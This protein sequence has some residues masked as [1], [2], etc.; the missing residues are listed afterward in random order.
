VI[1]KADKENEDAIKKVKTDLTKEGKKRTEDQ[2]K[3]AKATDEALAKAY[4]KAKPE[5]TKL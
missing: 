2:L 5:A 4:P 1:V 3:A